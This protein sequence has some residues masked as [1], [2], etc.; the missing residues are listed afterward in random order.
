MAN[1][2]AERRQQDSLLRAEVSRLVH[3]GNFSLVLNLHQQGTQGNV[4][5]PD[6]RKV[7]I[8]DEMF[9]GDLPF[10]GVSTQS[11]YSSSFGGFKF[12]DPIKHG[13]IKQ[14]KRDYFMEMVIEQPGETFNITVEIPFL[15]SPVM[16]YIRSS[17]RSKVSYIGVIQP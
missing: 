4:A 10:M 2:K 15:G 3:S 17:K 16:M 7:V 14:R 1:R 13:T 12:N 5:S 8:R 6:P 11:T 9:I